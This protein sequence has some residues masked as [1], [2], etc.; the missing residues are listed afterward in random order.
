MLD[1]R[2]N[3]D[4]GRFQWVDALRGIAAMVIVVNHYHHFYLADAYDRAAIPEVEY[5][6][7][8]SILMPLYGPFAANAVEL[9]WLIS[10]FV[11]AHV[12][13]A[14][15]ASAWEFGV[16]RFARLY[17]LHFAT[18]IYV[19]AMQSVSQSMVGHWQVYGNNDVKHFFLQV[20]MSSN[21]SN[22]DRGLSFNGP[23]WSVSLEI[24]IY[25]LFFISIWIMKRA[26]VL[27]SLMICMACWMWLVVEPI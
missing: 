13:L 17:P 22:W 23:I 4:I 10:G 9:F 19:A 12:Y 6:P 24:S 20:F 1:I 15:E 8:A 25:A 26:P 18:L 16:A 7:Y 5:F 3:S 2:N 11:F 21:W 27:V 14:R